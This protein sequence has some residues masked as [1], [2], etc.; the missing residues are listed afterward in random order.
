[1][2]PV[3]I[4]KSCIVA[5][6]LL[7]ISDILNFIQRVT[8][9]SNSRKNNW[10]SDIFTDPSRIEDRFETARSYI[11]LDDAVSVFKAISLFALFV[12]IFQASWLLS[13]GFKR[14][15]ANHITILVLSL[16]GG[17][18]ELLASLMMIGTR[19][20]V[21]WISR[22]FELNDWG[23]SGVDDEDGIGLRVLQMSE[24]MNRGLTTW[25]DAFE[26]LCLFGIFLILIVDVFD[27]HK[28][29][30]EGAVTFSKGWAMLG[31][32]IGALGWFEF[33]SDVLRIANWRFFT[34][35]ARG[36]AIINLW[37]LL[38]IWLL[39]TGT[40]LPKMKDKFEEREEEDEQ[41]PLTD[42]DFLNSSTTT[43]ADV[44]AIID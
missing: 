4:D 36:I 28:T 29:L 15:I 32:A 20:M 10:Y 22:D 42:V 43:T 2:S 41:V 27:E 30:K 39:M 11:A 7:Y 38:P 13:R 8:F 24:M 9:N 16:A 35:L 14:R 21:R 34:S 23:V 5:F 44:P 40:Q 18:C 37:L 17:M 19:S 3:Q 1:M 25:V 31:F 6:V 33:L 26:W 12:P